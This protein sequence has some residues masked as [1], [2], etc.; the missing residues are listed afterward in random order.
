MFVLYVR[1]R[2]TISVCVCVICT[3]CTTVSLVYYL[4]VNRINNIQ[5]KIV[6]P[7]CWSVF[8]FTIMCWKMQQSCMYA[9]DSVTIKHWFKYNQYLLQKKILMFKEKSFKINVK[10]CNLYSSNWDKFRKQ[11]QYFID[12]CLGWCQLNTCRPNV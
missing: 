7:G 12:R 1:T 11:R 5:S 9:C 2:L 10:L 4:N 8:F 6:E 3:Y